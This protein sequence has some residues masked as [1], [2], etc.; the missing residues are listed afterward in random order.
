MITGKIV[1]VCISNR[2]GIP[3]KNV[4]SAYLEVGKGLKG[5]AHSGPGPRQVSLL[6]RDSID[7]M[8]RKGYKLAEGS[9]AENLTTEGID[10]KN[11]A[12]GTEIRIGKTVLLRVTQIGKECHTKCAIFRKIGECIMPVEG[13]FAEVLQSGEIEIGDRIEIL[14]NN[15]D[16]N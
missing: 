8:R 4:H 10:L 6:A 5:D 2:K 16:L 12:I 11:L 9:F 3:K 7:K 15:T 13:I 14:N 1:G